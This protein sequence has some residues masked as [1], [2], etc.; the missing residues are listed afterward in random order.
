[1]EEAAKS[2]KCKIVMRLIVVVLHVYRLIHHRRVGV[3]FFVR[4]NVLLVN[5]R[6]TDIVE[7]FQQAFASEGIDGKRISQPLIVRH[8]LLLQIDRHAVT[9]VSSP[10]A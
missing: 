4:G 7:P 8:D 5:Q 10:C 3:L 6:E 9:L 1:M 2:L